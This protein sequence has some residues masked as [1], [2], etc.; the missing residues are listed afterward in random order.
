M[1]ASSAWVALLGGLIVL[2]LAGDFL[3]SSALSFARK[4]RISYL[5]TGIFWVGF[6]TSAPELFISLAAA[7]DGSPALALGNLVGSNIANIWLVLAIPAIVL[8]ISTQI[9]GL[10]SAFGL[11]LAA[12]ALFIGLTLFIP[13]TTWV[14]GVLLG[15]LLTYFWLTFRRFEP[16]HV[17]DSAVIPATIAN[18][19]IGRGQPLAGLF[20]G[21]IG[22]PLGAYLVVEGGVEIARAYNLSESLIG[23]TL[24]AIGTSLP[25]LA[26][27]LAAAVR[28]QTG[29]LIGNL[30]GSNVFNLLGAGGV[31]ALFGPVTVPGAFLRYDYW[32]LALATVSLA[33]FVLPRTK[34]S[35]LAGFALALV[36]AVYLYGLINGWNIAAVF[37]LGAT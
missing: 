6:G 12:T 29:L 11:L 30:I 18:P 28:R 32:V 21:L 4:Y 13:M 1:A 19:K 26:T 37:G 36:Y 9:A 27:S 16:D 35:R 20:I 23:L 34:I 14:G 7:L 22:L 5:S 17:K 8:P 10:R 15:G 3:V 33:S 2:V 25:E 31:I 24:L